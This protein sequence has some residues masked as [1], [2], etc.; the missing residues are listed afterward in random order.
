[1]KVLLLGLHSLEKTNRNNKWEQTVD[2]FAIVEKKAIPLY[3]H[4]TTS[5][6]RSILG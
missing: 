1:M 3:K 4:T 6:E 2:R 5:R